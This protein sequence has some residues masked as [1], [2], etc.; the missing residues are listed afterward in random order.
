MSSKLLFRNTLQVRNT[1]RPA[2]IPFIYGLAARISQIPLRD[3]VHNPTYFANSLEAACKLFK[4]DGITNAFDSSIEAEACGCE[5]AWVGDYEVPI[6]T[7]GCRLNLQRSDDLTR[8]N[9]LSVLMEVTKRLGIS[10][11]KEVAIIGVITGPLSLT[12]NLVGEFDELS[13]LDSQQPEIQKAISLAGDLLKRFI[14]G[15]CELRIDAVFIREELPVA[16][17]LDN[18]T[19]VK[20][21]YTTLFNIIRFYNS[22]PVLVVKNFEL[23]GIPNLHDL[24]RPDGVILC[25]NRFNEDDLLYLKGL[26][27]SLSICFGL[28]IPIGDQSVL[29]E[30]LNLIND[31]VIKSKAQGFFYT[32]DGE[33]PDDIPMET[34]HNV[35]GK[36]S[37]EFSNKNI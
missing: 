7:K 21:V 12:K 10:M 34:L 19:L 23:E 26:S 30:Q 4:Y 1:S 29:W 24:L 11:G 9:R 36:I 2:F 14:K 6:V 31:F 17:L 25:G 27:E 33:I 5:L 16:N 3:M 20:D 15:L 37:T 8:S 32:S 28:A 13:D 22:Y 18:L 35:T